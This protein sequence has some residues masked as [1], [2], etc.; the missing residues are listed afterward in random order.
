[1]ATNEDGTIREGAIE[2]LQKVLEKYK[3]E[4]VGLSREY[5]NS[6]FFSRHETREQMVRMAKALEEAKVA[7]HLD[8]NTPIA[9]GF[10]DEVQSFGRIGS[11]MFQKLMGMAHSIVADA[12]DGTPDWVKN[13]LLTAARQRYLDALPDNSLIKNLQ[14]RE[15]AQGYST[16]FMRVMAMRNASSSRSVAQLVTSPRFAAAVQAMHDQVQA[17][18]AD[19][20]RA[21]ADRTIPQEVANEIM[22]REAE[23]T[24]YSGNPALSQVRSFVHTTN[25]GFNPAYVLTSTSQLLTTGHPELAK[26]AGYLKAAKFIASATPRALRILRTL[27]FPGVSPREDKMIA[28]GNISK[29]DIAT[30]MRAD[31]DGA[32]SSATYTHMQTELG[33]GA[34]PSKVKVYHWANVLGSSAEI[35]P[36]IIMALATKDAYDANPKAFGKL[37]DREA[38]NSVV[39]NSQFK[40]GD[41]TSSRML[42]NRGFMGSFTPITMAFMNYHAKM[43]EKLYMEARDLISKDSSPE[44]RKQAGMFLMSHLIA[45][46]ALAGTLGLPFAASVA[47]VADK[48]A[49]T[50]TGKDD[51]DVEAMYR[52]WLAH[53]FGKD[54]GETIAKGVPRTALGF[55][56]S[57]LGDQ[58]LAPFKSVIDLI[59][60]KRK[61]EDAADDFLHSWSGSIF[62][63]FEDWIEGSRDLFN[64]DYALGAQ[65]IL[66]EGL[67]GIAES[68]YLGEHGYI[69]KNGKVLP[70]KQSSL[71]ILKK[72]MGLEPAKEAQY[73]E[74]SK[75][76]A[77]LIDQRTYR[78][79]NISTHLIRAIMTRDPASYQAWLGEAVKFKQDHPQLLGPAATLGRYMSRQMQ[80]Q[81]VSN[82]LGLPPTVAR[83]LSLRT[84]L[85][86]LNS[87]Q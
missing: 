81:G 13:G 2:G 84:N 74:A 33:E 34:D 87:N 83:D 20:A 68:Y 79:Q 80:Q 44:T 11:A 85:G 42:G 45:T 65:K 6:S 15:F 82:A 5:D 37:S 55:D 46:T 27:D 58:N 76:T 62:G 59:T 70:I 52:T 32:I 41:A 8:A 60:S 78:Q 24:I 38:V 51:I 64:G 9:N 56:L 69:D 21:Y 49:N 22:R 39:N 35:L 36:R 12:P 71:D 54:L 7:G 77:G 43:T 28:A 16:E 17:A 18:K 3:L 73:K 50:L 1:L 19:P 72:A 14:H 26:Y 47:S 23:S 30:I 63:D 4:G 53:T 57:H 31:N 86:F 40:Y 66:P 25:I 67:K 29:R 75:I 10:P 61:F 48:L